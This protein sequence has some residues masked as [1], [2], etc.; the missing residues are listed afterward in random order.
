MKVL[1]LQQ[2]WAQLVVTGA[3]DMVNLDFGTDFRG[4]VLI[5]ASGEPM[6]EEFFDTLP[7]EWAKSITNEQIFGNIAVNQAL[8]MN[9]AIGYAE[10]VDCT[11]G[12]NDAFWAGDPSQYHWAFK[13]AE[14]FDCPN[15]TIAPEESF[16]DCSILEKAMPTHEKYVLHYPKMEGTQLVIPVAEE[17]FWEMPKAEDYSFYVDFNAPYTKELFPDTESVEKLPVSKIR[18][19]H[20]DFTADRVVKVVA[21]CAEKGEDGSDVTGPSRHGGDVI[22]DYVLFALKDPYEG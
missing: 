17:E 12:E 19:S 22:Y 7:V 10:L 8:P 9:A 15:T 21:Y 14:I 6:T 4:K 11:Q 2:P 1:V 16:G 20:H 13:D 18:F 5:F 3:I